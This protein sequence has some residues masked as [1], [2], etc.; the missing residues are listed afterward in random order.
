M[1]ALKSTYVNAMQSLAAV[2]PLEQFGAAAT[3]SQRHGWRR[4]AA[5]LLAIYDTDRMVALDLPWWNVAATRAVE[6]FL[7]ERP[8]ARVFEWGAGAS[9]IWLARRCAS[10][11]SVEHDPDWL[12]RFKRQAD[13]RDNIA[14]MGRSITTDAYVAAIDEVGGLF[15]L[16]VVDG[17]QR[18]ACL[19]RAR[20][21]LAPQGLILFDD[22]GRARYRDG[23]ARAGLAEQRFFGRSYCVPYPDYTS[24]LSR[25]G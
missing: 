8:G 1:R 23:I 24:L 19:E 13:G 21:R 9:T 4:W 22:S 7:A 3:A 14:L 11:T 10:V 2:G 17:R 12:A 16:I 25:H 6:T 20:D 18:V 15:D 5:S